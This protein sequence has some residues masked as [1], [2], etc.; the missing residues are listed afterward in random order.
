V[1]VSCRSVAGLLVPRDGG[2]ERSADGTVLE[3]F[4]L[5]RPAAHWA[6]QPLTEQDWAHTT[7]TTR[8]NP[9]T[10]VCTPHYPLGRLGGDAHVCAPTL[11]DAM[12]GG[13][14]LDSWSMYAAM[15]NEDD[16]IHQRINRITD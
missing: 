6:A 13:Q 4:T 11:A 8:P 9:A 7:W 1:T 3:K 2:F 14:M 5:C 12:G 15:S 16:R 10:F